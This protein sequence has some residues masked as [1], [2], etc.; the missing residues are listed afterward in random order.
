[1]YVESTSSK[2]LPAGLAYFGGPISFLEENRGK[3]QIVFEDLGNSASIIVLRMHEVKNTDEA[4]Q[5]SLYIR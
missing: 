2:S 5:H 3:Y 4:F 1:M